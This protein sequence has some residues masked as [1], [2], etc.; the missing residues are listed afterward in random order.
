[1]FLHTNLVLNSTRDR[2]S[3]IVK[4][5]YVIFPIDKLSKN[6]TILNID[7]FSN[8]WAITLYPQSYENLLFC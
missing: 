4:A 6:C 1:M 7:I 3:N 8:I 5:N 2:F